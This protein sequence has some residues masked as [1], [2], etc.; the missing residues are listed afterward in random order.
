MAHDFAHEPDAHRYTLKIDDQLA[1][2]L[3]YAIN[4]KVIALTRT[5]TLPPY[6]GHGYAAELVEFAVNDIEATTSR[7]IVSSCWYVGLWFD[8][9]PER[10]DLLGR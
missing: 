8:E 5:Y 3:D 2:I 6:R 4:G 1:C 7:R 9:H 10:V